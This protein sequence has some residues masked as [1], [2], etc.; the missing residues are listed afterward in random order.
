MEDQAQPAPRGPNQEGLDPDIAPGAIVF[1]PAMADG[2]TGL[3]P[4]GSFSRQ[5]WFF[6]PLL[7][8]EGLNLHAASVRPLLAPGSS[9]AA[10]LE[11]GPGRRTAGGVRRR[12][13]ARPAARQGG[14][15]PCGPVRRV[16]PVPGWVFASGHKGMPIVP[17]TLKIDFLRRQVLMSR[18]VRGGPLVDFT[19]GGLN[20][21]IEHHLFPS[22]PR[23]N[24][25]RAQPLVRDYCDRHQVSYSEVGLFASYAIVVGYLNNVGLRARGPFECPFAADHR[26]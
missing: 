8:L 12:A 5:G 24:L 21:Q 11:S 10:R 23:P 2:R 17:R 9:P 1:T 19:M 14:C 6:F 18:N 15:V 22:M 20:Y 26:V 13:A 3:R 4:D 25:K 16:R 7:T